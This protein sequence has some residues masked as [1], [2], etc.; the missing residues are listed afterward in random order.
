MTNALQ[1]QIEAFLNDLQHAQARSPNTFLA[2][3]S[4][5]GQFSTFVQNHP[6]DIA[7][8]RA[9]FAPAHV[10]T[11]RVELLQR[12]NASST[13]ARKMAALASFVG[14]LTQQGSIDASAADALAPQRSAAP[15]VPPSSTHNIALVEA[16]TLLA[17]DYQNESAQ[18]LRDRA[19]LASLALL[20]LRVGE[21]AALDVADLDQGGRRVRASRRSGITAI[22]LPA[23]VDVALRR[24]L[25]EGRPQ[26]L[27]DPDEPALFL[28]HRGKRLTRQGI[29]LIVKRHADAAGIESKFTPQML[30]RAWLQREIDRGLLPSE[31]AERAGTS[32]ARSKRDYK[33]TA[34]RPAG[35]GATIVVDG[36]PY[37]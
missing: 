2:Y 26:L 18:G 34:A 10:E 37:P 28:N 13:V 8:A 15:F 11:W 32:G 6:S 23:S 16:E 21:I 33:R 27:V 31:Y 25:A 35:S 24:Y 9:G 17:S 12:G 3:R 36:K 19:L 14:W 1:R 20:G 4:D 22:A 7:I 30:R 5:L 29:W